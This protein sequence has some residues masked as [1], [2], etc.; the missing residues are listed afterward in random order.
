[1]NKKIFYFFTTKILISGNSNSMQSQNGAI[2]NGAIINGAAT[3]SGASNENLDGV[4]GAALDASDRHESQYE[5]AHNFF[6]K[7]VL[8]G[9]FEYVCNYN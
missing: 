8:D 6:G 4:G 7:A 3:G 1:M 2:V 9:D 5:L